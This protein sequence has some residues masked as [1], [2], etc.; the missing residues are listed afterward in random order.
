MASE[1]E[2]FYKR[3]NDEAAARAKEERSRKADEKRRAKEQE[4]RDKDNSAGWA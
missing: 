4:K 3:K 1:Q 2:K